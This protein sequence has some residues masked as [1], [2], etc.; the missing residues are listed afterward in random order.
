MAHQERQSGM[1]LEI[2]SE[3]VSKTIRDQA[4]LSQD[5]GLERLSGASGSLG[6]TLARHYSMGQFQA[7]PITRRQA[8]DIASQLSAMLD[9]GIPL[10]D[11]LE[12][13][14]AQ[15]DKPDLRDALGFIH[16]KI[17]GGGDLST[18][19]A[20]CPH[21]F[22]RVFWCLLRASEASG[23]MGEMLERVAEYLRDEQETVRKVR[24]ALIYPAVMMGLAVATL[25]LMVTFLLPR[26]GAIYKGRE[27]VLPTITRITFA[28][29]DFVLANWIMLCAAGI[30]MTVGAVIYFRS[31]RGRRTADWLKLNAPLFGRMFRQFYV[32]RSVRT[33]GSM[34]ASGLTIPE[35]VKLAQDITGNSYFAD[36]WNRADESL[37]GGGRLSDPLFACHLVPNNIAQMVATGEKT[38]RLAQVMERTARFCES[39]LRITIKDVTTLLEPLL[40]AVMAVSIGILMAAMLLPIFTISKLLT[41]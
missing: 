10:A 4:D 3:N 32:A 5:G 23:T 22:P 38:G 9:A 15:S 12:T 8:I 21:R 40:I 34:V 7:R 30:G 11:A 27:D 2:P 35:S 29:S 25:V 39:E 16:Q 13:L 6:R 28:L 18:A 19:V 14:A 20:A 26:F 36:L 37:Q 31:A 33:I 41:S 24:S 1:L 17:R